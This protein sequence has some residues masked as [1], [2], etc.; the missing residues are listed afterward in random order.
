MRDVIQPGRD[1]GHVDK[2]YSKTSKAAEVAADKHQQSQKEEHPQSQPVE[3][4]A[5]PGPTTCEDCQ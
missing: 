4:P 3:S 5:K 2:D 1:L